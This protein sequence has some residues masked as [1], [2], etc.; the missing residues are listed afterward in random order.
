M[1]NHLFLLAALIFTIILVGLLS[2]RG[3]VLALALPLVVYLG[4]AVWFSS[5]EVN[6]SIQRKLSADWVN[7]GTPVT[8]TLTLVNNGSDVEELL[9]QDRLP[10]GAQ[11]IDGETS[12]F[13]SLPA[14]ATH[15]LS[16]TIRPRRGEYN[17]RP[18]KGLAGEMFALFG[19]ELLVEAPNK[20]YVRPAVLQFSPIPIRPPQTRGFSGPIPARQAGSGVDFFSVREYEPGDPQR[21]IN[22]KIAARHPFDLFTNTHQAERVADVGIILDSRIQ[23]NVFAHGDSL[24][25]HS[26]QA[27]ASLAATFLGDGNRVALLVYGGSIQSVYPGYGKV[28]RERILNALARARL[29]RNYALEN[30]GHLPTRFFPTRSQIVLI[31]PLQFDDLPI[32]VQLRARGY[33]VMLIC[34]NALDFEIYPGTPNPQEDLAYRLANAERVFMLQQARRIGVQVVDWRVQ[35][36]LEPILLH[37][38]RSQPVRQL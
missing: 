35:D 14:R 28:Q 5:G 13:I 17:W 4:A 22:W 7:E 19:R 16:Y 6:L 25:E 23:L 1:R 31:S 36:P 30:L 24:F 20:L 11:L 21:H 38:V 2:L 15:E 29:G 9:L 34:P 18:M 3:D 33:A 12:L 10:P 8:V 32:L 37:T 26:T 27:A